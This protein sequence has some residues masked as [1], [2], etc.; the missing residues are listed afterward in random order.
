[1]DGI[2][3]GISSSI[4]IHR[5]VYG[6][7]MSLIISLLLIVSGMILAATT[8]GGCVNV[9]KLVTDHVAQCDVEM[10]MALEGHKFTPTEIMMIKVR[11]AIVKERMKK[12]LSEAEFAAF[13]DAINNAVITE[14][15]KG[16]KE[17]VKNE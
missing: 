17:K 8:V 4:T 12:Y 1:L 10:R 11:H 5:K 16:E 9:P 13:L 7:K 15:D 14:C 6:M 3:G 2:Y